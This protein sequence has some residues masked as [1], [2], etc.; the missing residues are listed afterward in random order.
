MPSFIFTGLIFTMEIQLVWIIH[1]LT[2]V[3]TCLR[4]I[5]M[6]EEIHTPTEEINTPK[7]RALD[8]QVVLSTKV[9]ALDVFLSGLHD[10]NLSETQRVLLCL[11]YRFMKGY[12]ATLGWRVSNWENDLDPK[13]LDLIKD[14]V[15]GNGFLHRLEASL[16]MEDIDL[17]NLQPIK[18]EFINAEVFYP[19][20]E[21]VVI[22]KTVP[23]GNGLNIGTSEVLSGKN[24]ELDFSAALRALKFG[25]RVQ[26][27]GWNG[28]DMWLSVSNLNTAT[29]DADKFWSPHNRE[30]AEQ[31]GGNAE[32]PPCITMKNAKGQ[33]Q[34]GWVA[35]QEDLFSNDWYVF[36]EKE[37]GLETDQVLSVRVE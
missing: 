36:M 28:K 10:V 23:L 18:A 29:V 32:V 4:V 2:V 12:L 22:R 8:E 25:Y 34:M 20:G 5:K 6:T 13:F 19:E 24:G 35:S 31:N 15:K 1:Y 14:V 37:A 7:G 11:Q 27:S 9:R 21:N 16:P 26:R 17:S 33:I 3:S 30:Y